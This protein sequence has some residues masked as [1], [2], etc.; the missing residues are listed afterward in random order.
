MV[1]RMAARWQEDLQKDGITETVAR[2]K[3]DR[4]VKL[5]SE[6]PILIV[7]CAD[8]TVMDKYPDRRRQAAERIMAIQSTAAAT[9]NLLLA[10]QAL[11]IGACW[12]CAPLFCPDIV[13]ASLAL[14]CD[15]EPLAFVTL[16][17]PSEN[18][19]M[20][21]RRGIDECRIVL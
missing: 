5:F 3:A 17:Y 10:A 7:A 9:Q 12:H 8:M 1:E 20:P 13:Q 19:S 11:G 16:G 2:A 14:T 15:Q 6:A 21:L 4:S 18:P